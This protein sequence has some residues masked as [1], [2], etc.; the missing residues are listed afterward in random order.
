MTVPLDLAILAALDEEIES[1]RGVLSD[2]RSESTGAFSVLRGRLEG[3]EVLVGRT[4]IGKVNAAL[5][6]QAVLLQYRPRA[7]L[8]T[9]VAGSLVPGLKV[10]D[11]VV[12]T[13]A[14]QHDYDLTAFDRSRGFVPIGSDVKS[15]SPEFFAQAEE[16]LGKPS[17]DRLQGVSYFETSPVLRQLAFRAYDRIAQRKPMP[18]AL[19]GAVASGDQFIADFADRERIQRTFGALCVEMEGA[20]AA[21][22]CFLS[23][24]PF[25]LLRFMSD[26]ADGSAAVHFEALAREVAALTA[27]LVGEIAILL[28]ASTTD[29][30][31]EQ[32]EEPATSLSRK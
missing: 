20:A 27:D 13:Q 7:I 6:T 19:A 14:I 17:M 28:H 22:A 29:S 2:V 24:T 9:G 26:A 30:A 10:G 23:G 12:A 21:H 32:G 15:A 4:G 5:H 31:S 25:L 11:L 3:C 16:I 8:F 1:L 18:P